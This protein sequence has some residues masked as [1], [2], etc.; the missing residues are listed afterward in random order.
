MVQ[1]VGIAAEVLPK[2]LLK[3]QSQRL[4]SILYTSTVFLSYVVADQGSLVG[5]GRILGRRA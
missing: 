3:I 4:L 1:R 2:N 5:K